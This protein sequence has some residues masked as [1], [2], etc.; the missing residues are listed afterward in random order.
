[1]KGLDRI[2]ELQ[3]VDSTIDR[4]VARAAELES[5]QAVA[6]ARRAMETLQSQ[7]GETRLALDAIVSEQTRLEHDVGMLE[8][9]RKAEETRLYDGSVV[10]PK[11][12]EA[13]Q[14]EVKNIAQRQRRYED[15]ILAQM[16]RREVLEAKLPGLETE[17][18][19]ARAKVEELES[20]SEHELVDIAE[21]LTEL[22]AEREGLLPAFEDELLDTYESL[23]SSKKGLAAVELIDGVCQGC[24][25]QLSPV[26]LQRVKKQ[27]GLRRCDHCRRILV[28]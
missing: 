3:G 1:M 18:E 16:E 21:K 9:K 15:D 6:T 19:A 5:G 24:H 22:R 7:L 2:L 14:A 8:Q 12:L 27:Q 11:E 25:Q 26:E 13:I 4:L 20:T 28:F 10:N 17:L 23:R